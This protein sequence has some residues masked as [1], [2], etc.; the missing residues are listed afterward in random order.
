M[1]LPKLKFPKLHYPYILIAI[2]GSFSIYICIKI[3]PFKTTTDLINFTITFLSLVLAFIAFIIA[4]QTYVSIDSVN[5]ISQMEGNVLE[6]ENYVISITSL[7]REYYMQDPKDVGTAIFNHLENKFKK[8]PKS[9]IEFAESLQEFI[10]LIVFFP[11]LFQS[12]DKHQKENIERMNNLL[13]TI[14]KRKVALIAVSTGNLILIEETVKLIKCVM[15]YQELIHTDQYKIASSLLDVR[16]A[17]I[18]NSVTQTVYYNYL[19]LFYNKKAMYIIRQK[20]ELGNRDFFDVEVLK[21]IVA[22]I[23]ELTS[24]EIELY[25]MY[26]D[27]SRSAFKKAIECCKNDIMWT[28]F[29]KYNDARSAFFSQLVFTEE[30]NKDANENWTSIMNEAITARSKL[31]LLIKDTFQES[32]K[33]HLQEAFIYQEY[34]ARLVKINILIA[35]NKDITDTLGK[36]IYQYPNYEGLEDDKYINGTY[37]GMFRKINDYQNEIV[38]Y[39]KVQPV[40]ISK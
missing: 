30:Y 31:N 8:K 28:G 37:T 25:K 33:S 29:I 22:Q 19:G 24:E 39:C 12:T 26:L 23:G 1:K 2:L 20:F 4:T 14:D 15:N 3:F 9:A 17:M 40:P 36:V 38:R 27:E 13:R 11:S 6:N 16:G 10:D 35:E 5:S 32:I 18:K 21:K 7:L 34:L